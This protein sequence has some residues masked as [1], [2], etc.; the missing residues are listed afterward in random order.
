VSW[1]AS[2]KLA[3]TLVSSSRSARASWLAGSWIR[4]SGPRDAGRVVVEY[5]PAR[6]Q[7]P[8]EIVDINEDGIEP[9]VA[10]HHRQVEPAALAHQAGR[11]ICDS[12]A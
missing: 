9:V 2:G 5:D 7:Q 6:A 11:A 3:R 8:P 1:A 4:R 12:P 10:V